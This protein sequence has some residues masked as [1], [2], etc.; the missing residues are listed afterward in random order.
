MTALW[1]TYFLWSEQA[2]PKFH[3]E[4]N[5]KMKNTDEQKQGQRE[6]FANRGNQFGRWTAVTP[7]REQFY[8]KLFSSGSLLP[9]YGKILL[10]NQSE[11]TRGHS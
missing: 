11:F 7:T 10:Q 2:L 8:N 4:L 1:R 3:V 9:G 5:T 6:T